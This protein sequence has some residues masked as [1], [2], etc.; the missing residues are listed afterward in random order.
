MV[1]V[2]LFLMSYNLT[3]D[4]HSSDQSGNLTYPIIKDFCNDQALGVAT[5][6]LMDDN[7]QTGLSISFPS[8]KFAQ[9]EDEENAQMKFRCSVCE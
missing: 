1:I 8:F 5:E 4:C 6:I 7:L 3:S 2:I 9:T